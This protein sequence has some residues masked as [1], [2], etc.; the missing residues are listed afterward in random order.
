MDQMNNISYFIIAPKSGKTDNPVQE[1]IRHN[2]YGS[3]LAFSLFTLILSE[4]CITCLAGPILPL[5]CPAYIPILLLLRIV[6]ISTSHLPRLYL[7]LYI[8]NRWV[9]PAA[10][11]LIN[12]R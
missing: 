5:L 12:K 9:F 6:R 1:K 3:G 7:L 10:S 4:I 2:V 8:I 11:L